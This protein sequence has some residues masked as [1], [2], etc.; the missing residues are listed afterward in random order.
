MTFHTVVKC[1]YTYSTPESRDFH[2]SLVYRCHRYD[3]TGC[4][5]RCYVWYGD[6]RR[7]LSSRLAT[8]TISNRLYFYNDKCRTLCSMMIFG[9]LMDRYGEKYVIGLSALLLGLT[10]ALL[11]FASSYTTLLIG[12]FIV[13][14]F[15]S[16]AHTGG[17]TVSTKWFPNEHRAHDQSILYYCGS[18]V[19]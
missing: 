6:H 10:A 17:S 12:V 14:L 11:P 15:Y 5:F 16:S 18:C 8:H 3:C 9:H 13:G 2:V 1:L 7:F 19:I 4:W